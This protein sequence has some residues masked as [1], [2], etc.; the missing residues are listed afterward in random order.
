MKGEF[1]NGYL[2]FF[3][4]IRDEECTLTLLSTCLGFISPNCHWQCKKFMLLRLFQ[5]VSILWTRALSVAFCGLSLILLIL[6]NF[7]I[8]KILSTYST[9]AVTKS[10]TQFISDGSKKCRCFC[11]FVQTCR[12][13]IIFVSYKTSINILQAKRKREGRS[14]HGII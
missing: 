13:P 9:K 7:W 4:L 8:F 12:S 5:L 14:E 11:R 10:G 2:H 3:S 6:C 1:L